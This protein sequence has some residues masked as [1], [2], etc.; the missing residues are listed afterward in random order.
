MTYIGF[1]KSKWSVLLLL[2]AGCAA[3][4]GPES[5]SGGEIK[6]NWLLTLARQQRSIT[7]QYADIEDKREYPLVL[8]IPSNSQGKDLSKIEY[9]E[10]DQR[11]F[12]RLFFKENVG[13]KAAV[14]A[15]EATGDGLQSNEP[16]TEKFAGVTG[17]RTKIQGLKAP[18]MY[19]CYYHEMDK[20]AKT[21]PTRYW[22]EIDVQ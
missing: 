7:I 9:Y 1:M 12:F 8:K 20:D 17:R 19:Y 18:F 22:L 11:M 10:V 2:L 21:F 6:P 16:T 14:K 15:T 3:D 13:W 4:D 5:A